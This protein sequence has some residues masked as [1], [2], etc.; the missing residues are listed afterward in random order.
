[1]RI[2]IRSTI[3]LWACFLAATVTASACL[4]CHFARP[5]VLRDSDDSGVGGE[6]EPLQCLTKGPGYLQT[7]EVEDVMQRGKE[8]DDGD[9]RICFF[10]VLH[11]DIATVDEGLHERW[12]QELTGGSFRFGAQRLLAVFVSTKGNEVPDVTLERMQAAVFGTGA[13]EIPGPGVSAV[14]HFRS[15]SH[16]QLRYVPAFGRGIANGILELRIDVTVAGSDVIRT[17][18]PAVLDAASV[19]VGGNLYAV[20]DRVLFCL[21]SGSLLDRRRWRAFA[22]IGGPYSYYERNTCELLTV[23]AHELGHGLGF[24]HSSKGTNEYGD[25]SCHLGGS[26]GGLLAFNGHKHWL[27]GWYE[28]RAVSVDQQQDTYLR[29]VSFVDYQHPALLNGDAVV[30]RV[31]ESLFLQYN[32][33]K[34]FNAEVGEPDTVTITHAE[35]PN[36]FSYALAA[37]HAG[38]SYNAADLNGTFWTIEVC[39]LLNVPTTLDYAIVNIRADNIYDSDDQNLEMSC[40]NLSPGFSTSLS[41]LVIEV[42]ENPVLYITLVVA[43]I[44]VWT[45]LLLLLL[46]CFR[47]CTKHCATTPATQL[48]D[49]ET[50]KHCD[51]SDEAK[52]CVLELERPTGPATPQ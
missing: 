47:C 50:E 48:R 15:I 11:D 34:G 51:T 26:P 44:A 13:A 22:H 10:P 3:I 41:L 21:P 2:S 45:S 42:Q 7:L 19:A 25:N 1:M 18:I 30:V 6:N 17:V 29:L 49:D 12:L 52:D 32:R 39:A 43:L 9:T 23:L 27:S 20:A 8:Q 14:D 24:Y 35:G 40:T 36:R 46:F 31:G 28:E 33:A 4:P 5:Q 38:Q 16:G 37:L